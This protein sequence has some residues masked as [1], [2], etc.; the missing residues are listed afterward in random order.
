[1]VSKIST[2]K[3]LI[4]VDPFYRCGVIWRG[5]LDEYPQ[6]SHHH[7]TIPIAF[8]PADTRTNWGLM[9]RIVLLGQP[10]WSLSLIWAPKRPHLPTA[11]SGSVDGTHRG[12]SSGSC[13]WHVV[14]AW[15]SSSLLFKINSSVSRRYVSQSL[16][17]DLSCTETLFRMLILYD[18]VPPISAI[19][20][21]CKPMSSRD[22]VIF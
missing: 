17:Q 12:Y 6:H 21:V 20:F 4:A 7:T 1:M 19:I 22:C 18:N 15:W 16:S 3:R 9:W 5:Y 13:S 2:S 10:N 8:I 14:H 11:P